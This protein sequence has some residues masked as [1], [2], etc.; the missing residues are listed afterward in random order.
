M[1]GDSFIF[2]TYKTPYISPLFAA[3]MR[4]QK[5]GYVI[6]LQIKEDYMLRNRRTGV[7]H[8]SMFNQV[9]PEKTFGQTKVVPIQAIE[10]EKIQELLEDIKTRLPQDLPQE[11]RDQCIKEFEQAFNSEE[12]AIVLNSEKVVESMQDVI[13][14]AQQQQQAK[15]AEEATSFTSFAKNMG[16]SLLTSAI[17]TQFPIA[18]LALA[19]LPAVAA[20]MN[21]TMANAT[22]TAM[23]P[24][25]TG[26]TFPASTTL[27]P[28]VIHEGIPTGGLDLCVSVFVYGCLQGYLTRGDSPWTVGNPQFNRIL[29]NLK[30]KDSPLDSTYTTLRDCL[31]INTI[32]TVV[33]NVLK[34]SEREVNSISCTTTSA[35]WSSWVATGQATNLAKN[36]CI[37]Y[38]NTFNA[39]VLNCQ[40]A[41]ARAGRTAAIT[42][43]VIG[44]VLLCACLVGVVAFCMKNNNNDC[45]PPCCP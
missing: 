26:T 9:V 38:Q 5:A 12:F 41:W 14:Q 4:A 1:I 34:T 45:E 21:S 20:Q 27:A 11:T 2:R 6:L 44:G 18:L 35:P 8:L 42:G 40:N 19:A 36:D 3:K 28:W 7:S 39:A 24:T 23:V 29:S 13:S 33:T 16:A 30:G 31:D 10:P 32:G 17:S 37:A 15:E 25:T 43:G 22:S